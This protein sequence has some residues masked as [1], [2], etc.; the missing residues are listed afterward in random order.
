MKYFTLFLFL[1]SAIILNAQTAIEEISYIPSRSGY[2]N[3]LVVKGNVNI[4]KILT[5]PLNIISY[6]SILDLKVPNENFPLKIESLSISTGTASIHIDSN[7]TTSTKE[8]YNFVSNGGNLSIHSIGSE[9]TQKASMDVKLFH[10]PENE[11]TSRHE[12]KVLTEDI[13]LEQLNGEDLNTYVHVKNLYIF[14]MKFP[15]C[16]QGYIWKTVKTADSV[17][18][19]YTILVC[20]DNNSSLSQ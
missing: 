3:N 11:S 8:L 16:P 10:F 19:M 18:T 14:G 12:I 6:S 2:Y 20:N 9:D 5:D 1:F 4:N 15:E 13:G 17:E 7:N